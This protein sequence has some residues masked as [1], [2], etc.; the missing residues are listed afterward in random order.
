MAW[1][2]KGEYNKAIGY[3][4]QALAIDKQYYGESHP[5]IAIDYNNLAGAWASKREY[6]RAVEYYEKSLVIMRQFLGEEH[7]STKAVKENLEICIAAKNAQGN[8]NS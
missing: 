2:F 1:K 3:Y 6:N 8:P 5:D 7:P 4:E